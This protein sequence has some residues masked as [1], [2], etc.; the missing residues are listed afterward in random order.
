MRTT[1]R[2][3][4]TPP[5]GI[6]LVF[7]GLSAAIILSGIFYYQN[8]GAQ[9]RSG[10]EQKLT[11][12]ADLKAYDVI[13][14][15]KERQGNASVFFTNVA[16]S[17]LVY[18][19][20]HHPDDVKSLAQ[21]GIWLNQVLKAY[22]Y[23][24]IILFDRT[25]TRRLTYPPDQQ[26]PVDAIVQQQVRK[27]LASTQILF[28]DFYLSEN[29]RQPYLNILVPI[30]DDA[31]DQGPLG[32][33]A[34]RIDPTSFLYPYINRW[35]E[36]SQSAE[37]L[38][39]RREGDDV[40][41]LNQQ[42]FDSNAAL[43][44]RFPLT[45]TSL[46]AVKA[47]LGKQGIVEGVDYR[48]KQ[49][50]AD[51]R[52]I[53]GSPWFMVTRMDI[54]EVYAPLRER[55]WNL[56]LL[57]SALMACVAFALGLIWRQQIAHLYHERFDAAEALRESEERYRLIVEALP[58]GV[59]IHADGKIIYGN[60]AALRMIG[61][62]NGEKLIGKPLIDFV[63]PDERSLIQQLTEA[64]FAAGVQP[65][66]TELPSIEERLI[67]LDGSIVTVDASAILIN[68]YGK[69][70]LMV[71]L[72]DI[73]ERKRA[74]EA[75]YHSEERLRA[76]FS[77]GVFGAF[78]GD[79]YGNITL[80]NDEFLRIIGYTQDDL[81]AGTV[82]WID[83]TPPEFLSVDKAAIA[84]A[85]LDG[86]CAPYEKQYV[87][88][89]GSRV[90]VL[91]GFVLV[92]PLR[93]DSIAF[94]LDLTTLK[95]KE[96]EIRQLNTELEKRVA[97][98]TGQ[99]ENAN[100]ELE[101]FAY[102]VSH[103]LRAPL[104]AISGY[105]HI[106]LEE[107]A[108]KLDDDGKQFLNNIQENARRMDRLITDLLALS[109]A[110]RIEL[111]FSVVDMTALVRSAFK[112][113][114]ALEVLD[115]FQ[116]ELSTL[117]DAYGDP[118]LIYQVWVNLLSNAIKYTLPKDER[119]IEIGSYPEKDTVVY[120]VRDTGVG[121]DPTYTHKLFGVFQRLHSAEDFAGTGVGLAI[122]QRIIYRHGGRTWAEGKLNQGATVYFSL[123]KR[124]G[125]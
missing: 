67:R 104:R 80:A 110:T 93:D 47:V 95:Q 56:I 77:S 68:Y 9:Y 75:L 64:T 43:R 33:L 102:S 44:L 123:P 85:K 91:V 62:S 83:L 114:A 25:G 73:T 37:T 28:E 21:L 1:G 119:R 92:G 17:K 18:T 51:V 42:R 106:V 54:A 38:I 3:G 12:I 70:A 81:A 15:R 118:N 108:A 87:R 88:K 109:R 113:I 16:F 23:D 60:N 82:R 120:Y 34:L 84:Q 31:A 5:Q 59:A 98:R 90:W 55:L 100:R 69:P 13:Q 101:A 4:R 10:I 111:E 86:A 107:Y 96:A 121:F 65:A 6:I 32:V 29:D 50:I 36:V 117:P 39:V 19:Y 97:E 72:N 61:A 22:E 27:A 112:E 76:F 45:Q 14:W 11:A 41:F 99:L 57:V 35:P 63:H 103:D 89:D 30:L 105:S 2:E 124:E 74:A 115:K 48:G 53:P 78:F 52:P 58:L 8:Y 26:K 94:I 79:V 122:V 7:L 49:V 71:L 20:F 40:L 24:Q 46:P 125:T 116:L 66:L